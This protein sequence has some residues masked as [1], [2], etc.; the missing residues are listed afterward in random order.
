MQ[1]WGNSVFKDGIFKLY[2]NGGTDYPPL[3]M[4]VL[5]FNS[6]INLILFGGSGAPTFN[7]VLVSKMIPNLCI[8]FSGLILF[9]YLREKHRRNAYIVFLSYCFNVA[10]LYNSSYWGQ[11]DSVYTM[12]IL[13][14]LLFL[15]KKGYILSS[16]FLLLGFFTKAQSVIFIPIVWAVIFFQN[17]IKKTLKIAE[18][19]LLA[20]AVFLLPFFISGGGLNVIKNL[21]PIGVSSFVTLNAYNLWFFIF[22]GFYPEVAISDHQRWWLFSF[23]EIGLM[24]LGIYTCLILYQLYKKND[25]KSIVLAMSSVALGFFML[26]TEIHERYMFPFFALFSLVLIKNIK[27]VLIYLVLMFTH[28]IN[29]MMTM[30][31]WGNFMFYLPLQTLI[32]NLIQT[33]SFQFVSMV[34]AGI[35]L[36]TF[37]YFL[38]TGIFHNLFFNIKND[39]NLIKNRW[40]KR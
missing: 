26:P 16:F 9:F 14:S 33:F 36:V 20:I 10:L 3:Y 17:G 19:N 25:N 40:A 13:I 29:M 22:P 31:F 35:N 24:L 34:I 11:V 6:W 28:L 32:N 38:K 30:G 1:Q 8:F 4:I 39:V 7:Y 27:Y 18:I 12:L 37:I 15:L 5:G 21:F 23:R 2:K